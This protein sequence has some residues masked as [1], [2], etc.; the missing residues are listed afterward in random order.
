MNT[1]FASDDVTLTTDGN[2]ML[3]AMH[4]LDE[5]TMRGL[6]FTDYAGDEWYWCRPVSDDKE[7]TVN[8]RIGKTGDRWSIDVLDE[9]YMQPYDYQTIV[10]ND[11]RNAYASMVADGCEE[12]FREL[13]DMGVLTGWNPGMYV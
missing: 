6:G 12:R 1:R 4:P 5:E 13:S 10:N 8:V 11:P 9:Y 7:I 3:L 2:N